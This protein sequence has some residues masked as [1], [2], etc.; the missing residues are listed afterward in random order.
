MARNAAFCEVGEK[1]GIGKAAVREAAFSAGSCTAQ[2]AFILKNVGKV[3]KTFD[4][5]SP[6]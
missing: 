1:T 5:Y 2:P 6:I 4:I 3:Q